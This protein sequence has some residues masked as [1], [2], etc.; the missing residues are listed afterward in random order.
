MGTLY[1]SLCGL[2][3]EERA[4]PHSPNTA[5]LAASPILPGEE[6]GHLPRLA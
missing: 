3:K 4:T 2:T 6:P 1:F 5:P